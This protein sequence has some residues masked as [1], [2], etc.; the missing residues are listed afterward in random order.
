MS[1][2]KNWNIKGDSAVALSCASYMQ[3]KDNLYARLTNL[4][5]KTNMD[6]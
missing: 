3:Y 5:Y 6:I 1:L 2:E 4:D